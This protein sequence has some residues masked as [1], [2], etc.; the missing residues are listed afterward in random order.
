M[1]RKQ[2]RE[3]RFQRKR[4]KLARLREGFWRRLLRAAPVLLFTILLTFILVRRDDLHEFAAFSQDLLM[5]LRATP[6]DARVLVVMIGDEEYE[7]EFKKDGSLN[8]AKLHELINAIAK[9]NPKV[10]GIDID[11]SDQRYRDFQWTAGL[12]PA[13]WVR[14]V[15]EPVAEIPIPRDVLGGTDPQLNKDPNSG[16]P[17][18]YDVNGVTRLYQRLI[19]TTDGPQSSFPW[20]IARQANPE[21]A[22]QRRIT[23]DRLM[24]GFNRAPAEELSASQILKVSNESWWPNNNQVREKIVLIGVSYLGQDRHQTP[25]GELHGVSNMAAAIVTELDGGGLEQPREFAFL[26]L[27][28]FQ[29]VILVILFQYFPLREALWKNLGWSLVLVIASAIVCS[30]IASLFVA[31]APRYLSLVYLAYFLPVGFLVFVEQLRELLNDW[32]KKKL[33]HVYGEMS[34]GHVDKREG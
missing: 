27:W 2:L 19:E 31:R 7:S 17:L 26:P 5:H 6:P 32:R 28:I 8:P 4:I 12:T 15:Y 24:I 1:R 18:L 25:L 13:V 11:T 22:T 21:I 16:L 33:A 20:A 30:F 9:G 29:S 3:K 34:Q 14:S 23:N 10:I